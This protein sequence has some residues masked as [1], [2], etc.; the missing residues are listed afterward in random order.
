M[1]SILSFKEIGKKEGKNNLL[2][3]LSFGIQKGEVVSILGKSNSGKSMLFKI[4]MGLNNKNSGKIFVD[5]MDY[6][7]RRKEIISLMGYMPQNHIFDNQLNI[8]E[9]LLFYAQL[10]GLNRNESEEKVLHWA[11]ELSFKKELYMLPNLVSYSCLRKIAFAR[12]LISDPHFLLLDNPAFGMDYFDKDNIFKIIDKIKE[13]KTILFIT[14][15]FNEAE[16]HSDRVI[17]LHNGTVCIN[18]SLDK[19][20]NATTNTNKYRISFKRIVPHDFLE[21]VKSNKSIIRFKSMD[22]HI[23]FV[24]DKK[25]AFFKVL[26]SALD[27]D[28]DD[29]KT[30]AFKLDEV[31]LKVTENE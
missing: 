7:I 26:Q 3:N 24:T 9:N 14:Q 4:L 6:D 8:F 19:I 10:K 15:N 11:N 5:G 28:L 30:N 31:F 1:A 23:E 2:A 27:Y 29:I 22:R 13:K 12:S 17:I 25:H 21:F 20:N 18:S 16:L